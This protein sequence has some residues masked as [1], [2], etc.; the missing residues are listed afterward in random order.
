MMLRAAVVGGRPG[1]LVTASRRSPSA[2]PSNR[3][4]AA[5]AIAKE[6]ASTQYRVQLQN[7]AYTM[8]LASSDIHFV[9]FTGIRSSSQ[10]HF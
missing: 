6:P 9:N 3:D 1:S 10:T 8:F 5:I 2:Q 7:K 4:R